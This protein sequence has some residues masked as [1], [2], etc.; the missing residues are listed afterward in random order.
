MYVL[1]VIL[2]FAIYKCCNADQDIVQRL[3]GQILPRIRSATLKLSNTKLKMNTVSRN[4]S[5]PCIPEIDKST[6]EELISVNN[7]ITT[8]EEA[9]G[10]VLSVTGDQGDGE[11]ETVRSINQQIEFLKQRVQNIRKSLE[12]QKK[13]QQRLDDNFNSVRSQIIFR[14]LKHYNLTE[15]IPNTRPRGARRRSYSHLVEQN[16]RRKPITPRISKNDICRAFQKRFCTIDDIVAWDDY[17][18]LAAIQEN[19]MV[20]Y[21][22][23]NGTNL[24]VFN[25]SFKIKG[26]AR[27]GKQVVIGS[28]EQKKVYILNIDGNSLNVVHVIHFDDVCGFDILSFEDKIAIS[29]ADGIQIYNRSWSQLSKLTNIFSH[30]LNV[31]SSAWLAFNPVSRL[32]LYS[33]SIV[34]KI[35]GVTL[36]GDVMFVK[37]S[38][39]FPLVNPSGISVTSNGDTYIADQYHKRITKYSVSGTFMTHIQ[40]TNARAL[41]VTPRNTLIC[42]DHLS[43]VSEFIL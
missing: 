38:S 42:G 25:P 19:N 30:K 21:Q 27:V 11:S 8:C 7:Y 4:E 41:D 5:C 31:Q 40:K 22:L 29:C 37:E 36:N 2:L 28:P 39:W 34:Q 33:D 32:L 20:L 9:F 23:L 24:G 35:W 1:R 10:S 43:S 3:R 16:R 15:V 17:T 12:V 14:L 6:K 13:L 26:L 18:Y